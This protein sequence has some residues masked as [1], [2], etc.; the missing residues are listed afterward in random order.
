M[1]FG[2][3]ALCRMQVCDSN[4]VTCP[5]RTSP[6]QILDHDAMLFVALWNTPPACTPAH[7]TPGI[8]VSLPP[9]PGALAYGDNTTPTSLD[10]NC[11]P[12]SDTIDYPPPGADRQAQV[13]AGSCANTAPEDAAVAPGDV[14]PSDV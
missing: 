8:P 13:L 14:T 4:M 9:A 3:R 10:A 2:P 7:F 11:R 6:S 12:S 1:N 5:N